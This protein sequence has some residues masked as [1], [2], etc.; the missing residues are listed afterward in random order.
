MSF[1]ANLGPQTCKISSTAARV[2]CSAGCAE[3]KAAQN[4][5]AAFLI[6]VSRHDR[7]SRVKMRTFSSLGRGMDM[8]WVSDLSTRRW[9]NSIAAGEAIESELGSIKSLVKREGRL[10]WGYLLSRISTTD[11]T[12]SRSLCVCIMF[13]CKVIDCVQTN[14]PAMASTL[15]TRTLLTP[16]LTTKSTTTDDRN[17]KGPGVCSNSP[18]LTIPQISSMI[19]PSSSKAVNMVC[20]V[21]MTACCICEPSPCCQKLAFVSTWAGSVMS[22]TLCIALAMPAIHLSAKSAKSFASSRSPCLSII[23]DRSISFSTKP[24]IMVNGPN[25]NSSLG[26]AWITWAIPLSTFSLT[27][28][29][30]VG[31]FENNS[32]CTKN[33]C[34][35]LMRYVRHDEQSPTI[36]FEAERARGGL[37]IEVNKKLRTV[38]K[39]STFCSK[40]VAYEPR[41]C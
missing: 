13:S 2:S 11:K 40:K 37:L 24:R 23:I 19:S 20:I 33:V 25:R 21:S 31:W 41:S 34:N 32:I 7:A 29:S 27:I 5:A 30:T 4:F 39:Y 1:S 12:N 8:M 35:S 10:N 9:R 38:G 28:V 16:R 22:S 15:S 3:S 17:T 14:F 36:D 26:R 18:A 6:S